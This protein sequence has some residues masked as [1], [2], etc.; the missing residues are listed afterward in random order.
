M[1]KDMREVPDMR[2]IVRGR[3]V[4]SCGLGSCRQNFGGRFFG[5]GLG[6]HP[7]LVG[8]ILI[9]GFLGL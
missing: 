6:P 3:G 4:S 8:E 1:T 2:L 9:F 5:V 7:I